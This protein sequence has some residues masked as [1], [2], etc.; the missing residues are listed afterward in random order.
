MAFTSF[1]ILKRAI[2][3]FGKDH[4]GQMGAALAYYTLFSIAP[5]LILAI[6]MAGYVYGEENARAQV[7][8]HLREVMTKDSADAVQKMIDQVH[9]AQAGSWAP[10]L[11]L[12][13][14]FLGA[15]G[16]FLHIRHTLCIIW[17]L[18]PPRGN[19]ILG[20]LLNY[21]LAIL[22]ILITGL[23]LLASLAVSTVL[24]VLIDKVNELF[25][26]TGIPWQLVEFGISIFFLTL[27]FAT[28]YSVL[29]G[30]RI[31]WRYVGFGSLIAAFLFTIG[32]TLLGLYL[33]Y[34]TTASMYGA[35]AS[36]VAFLIWVFYSS[37]ILFFGAELIQARRSRR[38]WLNPLPAKKP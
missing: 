2:E 15:L 34:S 32:K 12:G 8:T 20:L 29:S 24:P 21:L 33:V 27:V 16:I 17:K 37:Q 38:E 14:L 11:G 31:G 1:R 6:R 13:L 22:M 30:R 35:A 36:V 28:V 4:A 18:E 9:Q 7:Y 5:L 10:E 26:G 25:P 3:Q 19:S 23:L